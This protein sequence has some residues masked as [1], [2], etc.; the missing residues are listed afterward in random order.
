M[1][2]DQRWCIALMLAAGAVSPGRWVVAEN[3]SGGGPTHDPSTATEITCSPV[4]ISWPSSS[5]N[6]GRMPGPELSVV[7]TDFRPKDV[8]L[9]LDGRFVGRARFFNGKKGFL[10]LQPGRYELVA[11]SGGLKTEVFMI[12]A[13]AGC[14]FDIKH[15]MVKGEPGGGSEFEAP[16]GKGKPLQWIY[17]PVGGPIQPTE[18]DRRRGA[19]PDP[20]LRP[21]LG[22]KQPAPVDRRQPMASLR[23]R[24]KP[25]TAAVYLDGR[26]LATGEEIAKM[27]EPLAVPSGTRVILV[28]ATGYTDRTVTVVVEEGETEELDI[29]LEPSAP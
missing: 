27:V 18:P 26:M 19:G 1:V 11:A 10:Y 5:S 12:N 3:G 14:R 20:R 2:I 25:S 22:A 17:G 7:S 24:V 4:N 23:I 9:F 21:D 15:R 8:A 6:S 28:R 16:P 29:A 13:R